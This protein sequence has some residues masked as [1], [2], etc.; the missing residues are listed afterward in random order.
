M[1]SM[2]GEGT[3]WQT[4]NIPVL[5]HDVNNETKS[6]NFSVL[7]AYKNVVAVVHK[8]LMTKGNDDDE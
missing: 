4:T 1:T 8:E 5:L 3:D 2:N 6:T 7:F